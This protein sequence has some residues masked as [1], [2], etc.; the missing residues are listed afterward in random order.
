MHSPS[1][2]TVQ[3]WPSPGPQ[4]LEKWPILTS[5]VHCEKVG[6]LPT[7][8]SV[9][10]NHISS[11][12]Q[13]CVPPPL[14]PKNS[15]LS[16]E[17]PLSWPRG[18][19][20]CPQSATPSPC[21]CKLEWAVWV[22]LEYNHSSRCLSYLPHPSIFSS[23]FTVSLTGCH[24][25]NGCPRDTVSMLAH[26]SWSQEDKRGHNSGCYLPDSSLHARTAAD[27]ALW[28]GLGEETLTSSRGMLSTAG[29]SSVKT[30]QAR[31]LIYWTCVSI[32]PASLWC[33]GQCSLIRDLPAISSW[34]SSRKDRR[35]QSCEMQN[36]TRSGAEAPALHSRE[37][38]RSQPGLA[39]LT[40]H[41][42]THSLPF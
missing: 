38:T 41:D 2:T 22:F 36:I 11:T 5:E 24:L 18:F 7:L 12:S 27:W 1:Q 31:H 35:T 16:P 26:L 21:T 32:I 3:T 15:L 29:W 17:R 20:P 37:A 8:V 40:Q 19:F 33:W 25:A 13:T 10:A 14:P 30:C 34:P 23:F 28:Q 9:P 39:Y 42:S 4:C 6:G